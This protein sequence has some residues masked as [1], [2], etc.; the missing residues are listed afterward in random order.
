MSLV[1]G[2]LVGADAMQRW[3]RNAELEIGDDD[4]VLLH[5]EGAMHCLWI[6]TNFLPQLTEALGEV[7]GYERA[8]KL[9]I[10]EAVCL[11][12]AEPEVVKEQEEGAQA[13]QRELFANESIRV[14]KV[15]S[16]CLNPEHTFERFV[17]G[18][19]NEFA[20]AAC[21]AIAEGKGAGYSPLFIHG[22]A[23]MG[24]T[25]LTQ[26]LGHAIL[27]RRPSARVLYL[28]CE[29]F[30]NEF[31]GAVQRGGLERFRARYRKAEVL[32][33]DDVQFLSGKEKSG[34]EFFHTYNTLL[35]SQAQVI[36]TS[37]RPACE[38][39]TLEPRLVSRFESGL[40]VAMQPASFEMRMAILQ[41]K[42]EEWEVELPREILQFIADRIKSN[43]RRLEGALVRVVSFHQLDRGAITVSR[44]ENL[45][46][47][48]LREEA[49]RKV[50]IDAIQKT[51]SDFYD[52]QVSDIT[53][54]RRPQNIAHARQ[55]AMYLSR[56]MTKN[57]LK[58]IGDAFGGRDHGTII[59]ACKKVENLQE[60]EEEVRQTLDHLESRLNR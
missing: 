60:M 5:V 42:M 40:T 32:I 52:L 14:R 8:A 22:D 49:S 38:I 37:D 26:A 9:K 4:Q 29:R 39:Q 11:Q 54:R 16:A 34:D 50:T 23:G 18:G 1:L 28:T 41:K 43:I 13:S 36:L 3:F 20:H 24:K 58:E 35:D 12:V 57:S 15:K 21:K 17:V 31:I 27:E 10:Q 30:T 44:V 56:K 45:L 55:V 47:D 33:V 53:G 51:V 46:R 19:S 6:E 7:V 48:I 2:R 59:H 25:H